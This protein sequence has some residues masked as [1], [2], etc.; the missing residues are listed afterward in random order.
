VNQ[1]LRAADAET[2]RSEWRKHQALPSRLALSRTRRQADKGLLA[3]LDHTSP[4]D[5]IAALYPAVRRL[6]G[7]LSFR[8]VARRF[9]FSEP[10]SA[11]IPRSYGDRVPLF[12]RSL[13]SAA[14]IEYVADIAELEMLRNKAWCAPL[15]QPLG[16]LALSSLTAE[17]LNGLRV[18]LHPS[19]CLVQSRFPVVSIWEANQT[20]GDDR[21]VERWVPEAALVARPFLEIEVRKLPPGGYAFLR[22]LSG[23]QTVAMA[24]SIA[25]DA[26]PEFDLLSNLTLLEDA[27][28]IIG[29]QEAC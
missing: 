7:E 25:T 4:I 14:C 13:G 20:D 24:I 3:R 2:R 29:I 15:A 23:G 18:V 6:V 28:V 21:V 26:T 10:P 19:V 9:I 17:R 27:E 22:A 12:I 8:V 1:S 16:A 11:P 5:L